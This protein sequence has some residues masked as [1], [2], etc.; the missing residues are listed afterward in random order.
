MGEDFPTSHGNTF[1]GGG[2]GHDR[3]PETEFEKNNTQTVD[4]ETRTEAGE[5]RLQAFVDYASYVDIHL[6]NLVIVSSIVKL[7]LRP[8]LQYLFDY[9]RMENYISRHLDVSTANLRGT[10]EKGQLRRFP[11]RE[12]KLYCS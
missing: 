11:D 5:V 1:G 7:D 8:N 6:K 2:K 10:G 9:L 12:R 4:V 3:F